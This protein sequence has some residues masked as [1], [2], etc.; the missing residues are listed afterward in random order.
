MG[1]TLKN[2]IKKESSKNKQNKKSI[3]KKKYE[4]SSY[5]AKAWEISER[6]VRN[7]C[8]LGRIDNAYLDGKTWYIPI[9]AE[10]PERTNKSSNKKNHLLDRL[11][12]KKKSKINGGIY[13]KIQIDLTYNSNHIEGSKL[14]HEE[15]RYIFETKTINAKK[16]KNVDDIIETVNHFK[17]V[18]MII[19]NANRKLTENFIKKLHFTLKNGTSDSRTSWFK[20]GDYKELPNEVGGKRTTDPKKVKIEIKN[21]LERYN[22]KTKIDIDDLANFHYEFESIH[23]FQDG[24]GRIG[25]LILFK[26]C[27]K[28]NI[29]PFIITDEIKF[30]YYRGLDKWKKEKGYLIDT[31]LSAQ[32]EFK[33]Y[34]EY[35]KIKE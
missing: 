8:A 31:F 30:Y 19:E 3:D 35:F 23:P 17:C 15:T 29:V 20:V 22:K 7:Y 33:K 34:M 24:N 32:D 11:I 4:S 12:K 5:F 13:Y 28:N 18:D 16:S 27:L 6:S 14:T 9:N 10:K 26:E 2:R 1:R 21:L 25:R